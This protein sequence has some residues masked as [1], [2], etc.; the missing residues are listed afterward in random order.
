M[1][2]S[3]QSESQ[4][5]PP[6]RRIG[7]V[8]VLIPEIFL[9]RFEIANLFARRTMR[10]PLYSVSRACGRRASGHFGFGERL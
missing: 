7:P 9:A 2:G 1:I 10:H 8:P 3:L 6:L 5:M 4:L